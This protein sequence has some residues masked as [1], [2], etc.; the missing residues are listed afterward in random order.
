[1]YPIKKICF[2]YKI[3]NL[4][5][6]KLISNFTH[7]QLYSISKYLNLK[8]LLINNS[9]K[10]NILSKYSDNFM[11][12]RSDLAKV[13]FNHVGFFIKNSPMNYSTQLSI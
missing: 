12:Y 1:M 5:K 7:K 3:L 4:R 6:K 11:H 10:Q 9:S 13:L 8:S 2:F